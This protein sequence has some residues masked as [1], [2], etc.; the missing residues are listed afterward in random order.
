M[1]MLQSRQHMQSMNI[2]FD[3]YQILLEPKFTF[4]VTSL[5]F[6]SYFPLMLLP[7]L[8]LF[9]GQSHSIPLLC[10][11]LFNESLKKVPVT[12]HIYDGEGPGV[13][14]TE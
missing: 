1:L 9:T 14:G 7:M 3:M 4:V 6:P 2:V 5:V 10:F 11:P 8:P 12:C 13:A